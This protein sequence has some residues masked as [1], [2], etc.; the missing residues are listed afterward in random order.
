[1]KK[2]LSFH[3]KS[4]KSQFEIFEMIT[5]E[6]QVFFNTKEIIQKFLKLAWLLNFLDA[7]VAYKFS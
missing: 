5:V 3:P 4:K 2:I 7:H 6:M 1:M